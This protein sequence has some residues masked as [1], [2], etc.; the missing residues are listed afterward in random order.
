MECAHR[1]LIAASNCFLYDKS[2]RKRRADEMVAISAAGVG[3]GCPLS[4]KER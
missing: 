4:M 2:V 1:W 3:A